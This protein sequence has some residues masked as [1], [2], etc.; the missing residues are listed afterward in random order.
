MGVV[1]LEDGGG[2]VGT[3]EGW[4]QKSLSLSTNWN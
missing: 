3:V 1:L 2:E 4:L